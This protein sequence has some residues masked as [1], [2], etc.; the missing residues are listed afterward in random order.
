[1]DYFLTFAEVPPSTFWF[2]RLW[3]KRQSEQVNGSNHLCDLLST[4]SILSGSSFIGPLFTVHCSGT[5]LDD[6]ESMAHA[7][8]KTY[9]AAATV[10]CKTLRFNHRPLGDIFNYQKA[11]RQVVVCCLRHR[12]GV[13]SNNMT[14]HINPVVYPKSPTAD[15]PIKSTYAHASPRQSFVLFV[16]RPKATAIY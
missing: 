14:W 6:C 12:M 7:T 3:Q 8:N 5:N 1:M 9:P 16:L 11:A 10:P 13:I 4:M 2:Y 15:S